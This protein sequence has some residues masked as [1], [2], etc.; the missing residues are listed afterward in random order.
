MLEILS[1]EGFPPVLFPAFLIWRQ[2]VAEQMGS[3]EPLVST[4]F[5]T[6]KK[7]AQND[8]GKRTRRYR[9]AAVKPSETKPQG[10]PV[11]C[12]GS[13][14]WVVAPRFRQNPNNLTDLEW[15]TTLRTTM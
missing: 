6:K 3:R 12:T 13:D 4:Y 7:E 11:C 5:F 10:I 8:E 2:A 1:G 14:G 15:A 9:T